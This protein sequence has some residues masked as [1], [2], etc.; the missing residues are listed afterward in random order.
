M[1]LGHPLPRRPVT[2]RLGTRAHMLCGFQL[3]E[4][5]VDCLVRHVVIPVPLLHLLADFVDVG[6]VS[7]FDCGRRHADKVRSPL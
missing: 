2:D 7:I 4:H 3:M 5:R 6:R 1:L